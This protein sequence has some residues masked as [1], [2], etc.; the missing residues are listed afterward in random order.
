M[1]WVSQ[2]TR[3]A[4]VLLAGGASAASTTA[5]THSRSL[6]TGAGILAGTAAGGA[7]A[8]M[9][10]DRHSA[11]RVDSQK[12][13]TDPDIGGI[14]LGTIGIA[15]ATGIASIGLGITAHRLDSRGVKVLAAIGSATTG[16]AAIGTIAGAT[17]AGSRDA[18]K[19]DAFRKAHPDQI[20]K[21]ALRRPRRRRRAAPV[22]TRARS[23][24][25]SSS[26]T[27]PSRLR[28]RKRSR[29]APTRSRTC[30]S[31]NSRA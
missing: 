14:G 24:H 23:R 5:R 25:Q 2:P 16:A 19:V 17:I 31:C 18:A 10:Q 26:S 15:A 12:T 7:S 22:P 8:W 6:A 28:S 3:P 21:P 11:G 29:T 20:E 1:T 30:R 4:S 13:A 27:P 9:L